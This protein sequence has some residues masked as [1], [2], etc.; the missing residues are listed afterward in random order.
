MRGAIEEWRLGTLSGDIGRIAA[1]ID[2]ARSVHD[3]TVGLN[4][5]VELVC[6]SSDN[7][8]DRAPE[9]WLR[10]YGIGAHITDIHQDLVAFRDEYTL[11]MLMR[12]P[13][14]RLASGGQRDDSPVSTHAWVDAPT[15]RRHARE[16]SELV[17]R[18]ISKRMN[19]KLTEMTMNN[20][21]TPIFRLLQPH[22]LRFKPLSAINIPNEGVQLSPAPPRETPTPRRR[23]AIDDQHDTNQ[24]SS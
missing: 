12:L 23:I 17:H 9:Y 8:P 16:R 19:Y 4:S 7:A 15:N 22:S 24:L 1:C 3:V 14:P 11:N 13:A 6:S 20:L 2:A 5:K 21:L 18:P 10:T